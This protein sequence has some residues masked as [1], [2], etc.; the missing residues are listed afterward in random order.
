MKRGV[1]PVIASVLMIALAVTIGVLVTNWAT[2]WTTQRVYKDDTCG[3]DTNYVIDS[4]VFNKSGDDLLLLMVTNK[5]DQVI[6]GFEI[7]VFNNTDLIHF[8]ISDT[9]INQGGISINNPLRR[10][11]TALLKLNLTGSNYGIL[12]NTM[13]EIRL[14]NSGCSAV[15]AKT[16]SITK[17]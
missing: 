12:G 15:S 4:A 3:I 1:S 13:T 5:N 8:N 14:T 6:Y 11:S 17:Y 10:E 2:T 7:T 9:R 16:T